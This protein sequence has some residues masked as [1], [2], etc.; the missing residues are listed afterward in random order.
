MANQNY[1]SIMDT[2]AK[3]PCVPLFPSDND[4]TAVRQ[5]K[6]FVEGDVKKA[7]I[8]ASNFQLCYVGNTYIIT[9]DSSPDFT[10]AL[11]FYSKDS[12]PIIFGD[13]IDNYLRSRY[14]QPVLEES[15]SEKSVTT[16]AAMTGD[17]R[18][19]VENADC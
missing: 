2:A 1:Y 9:S 7:G 15:K 8:P 18:E 11:T 5:F 14:R 19:V 6:S 17:F 4:V 10:A 12:H 16:E 3:Q 13:E